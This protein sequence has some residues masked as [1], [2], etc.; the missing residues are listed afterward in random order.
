MDTG[1]RQTLNGV[2][3]FSAADM[4]A[5]GGNSLILHYN[6]SEWSEVDVGSGFDLNDIWCADA[7]D[8]RAVGDGGTNIQA[9]ARTKGKGKDQGKGKK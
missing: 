2:C 7:G 4:Y 5:V 3:G 8:I 6:G 1:T 9:T